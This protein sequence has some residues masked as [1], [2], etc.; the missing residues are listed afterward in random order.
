TTGNIKLYLVNTTDASFLRST[1]WATLIS[2]PTAMQLVYDGPLT[3]PATA[4][5]YD[6]TLTTPFN[7]T[8]G[9]VYMAFEWTRSGAATAAPTYAA[10]NA[11][12]GGSSGWIGITDATAQQPVL[13]NSSLFR[14][15][16]RFGYTPPN[17]DAAVNAVYTLGKLPLTNGTVPTVVTASVTNQGA[18]ALTN[19]TFTLTVSGANTFTTTA[20]VANINP[21]QTVTVTFPGFTPTNLGVN[22]ITVTA[23]AD[24][25]AGN[26]SASYSQVVTPATIAYAEGNPATIVGGA[27][28]SNGAAAGMGGFFTR[29]TTNGATVVSIPVVRVGIAN[30]TPSVGKRVFAVV[31]DANGVQIGRSAGYT[32]QASDLGTLVSFNI[33]TPP[34]VTN[35]D[36]YVGLAVTPGP[37]AYFPLGTQTET[38]TRTGAYYAVLSDT[39]FSGSTAFTQVT[40]LGRYVIE[41]DLIVIPPPAID[42]NAFEIT[43][44]TSGCGLS[45]TAQVCATIINSGSDP[46]SN[47]PVSYV[48]NGGTPVTA[49]IP[50]TLAAGDT[51]SYCFSQTLD[52]SA[53]GTYNIWVIT[54]MAGDQ[55]TGNDT[56]SVTIT[57]LASVPAAINAVPSNLCVS[58]GPI[59]LSGSPAGGTFS[60]NGVTG[61][62][63]DPTAAGIG[64]HTIT[65]TVVQG[66]C[67]GTATTT[68]VVDTLPG[69]PNVSNVTTCGFGPA[70]LTATTAGG[71]PVWYS[72]AT[73]G[74]IIGTGNSFTTPSL[75]S[76]TTYYVGTANSFVSSGTNTIQLGNVGPVDGSIGA[77]AIGGPFTN[78]TLF[79]TQVP[80]RI[81]SVTMITDGA[82]TYTIGLRNTLSTNPGSMVMDSVTVSVPAAGTHR[83]FLGIE[84]PTPGTGYTLGLLSS[85]VGSGGLFR[86]TAGAT[87]PYV[88]PG[89]ISIT[90][91]AFGTDPFTSPRFYNFY[92]W[93][94]SA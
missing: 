64:S 45:S 72:A 21:S 6:I 67:S 75:S 78:E 10:N 77:G 28:I 30:N 11:A 37:A 88:N 60:G 50:G 74:T 3:I 48:V 58:E 68:I 14:P 39:T 44:L 57:S 91:A 46:Q 76:N 47:I 26:N 71:T 40:T 2:S 83:V 16:M 65:Y 8:G 24:D 32:I 42:L 19:R 7:Y 73:G 80:L 18:L 43:G 41:A 29:Y 93:S 94:V 85:T 17:N 70:T 52:L 9:G 86:N 49:T 87:F 56:A 1:T 27:G 54:G 38:P 53:A 59:Q 4:G 23:P 92:N 33:A 34:T 69:P 12:V 82:G 22:T 31:L 36:F 63:F 13:G 15:G 66:I 89:V 35:T 61:T 62:T 25:V 79:N 51:M 5:W 90:G 20:T 84:V 81:D 55:N